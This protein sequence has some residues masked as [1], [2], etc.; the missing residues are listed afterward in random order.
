MAIKVVGTF[1]DEPAYFESTNEVMTN[2]D[3]IEA[4]QCVDDDAV[5]FINGPYES[6]QYRIKL[7]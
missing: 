5:I 3:L 4:L 2:G 7:V 6:D 1:A